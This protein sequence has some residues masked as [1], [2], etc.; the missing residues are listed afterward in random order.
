WIIDDV[1]IACKF[2][3]YQKDCIEAL[4]NKQTTKSDISDVIA[5]I[6]VF[7]PFMPTAKMTKWFGPKLLHKL[8]TTESMELPP[9]DFNAVM[10]A[11]QLCTNG[12]LKEA[13]KSLDSLDAQIQ[14]PDP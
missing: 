12:E 6:G 9:I 3:E 5:I 11:I 14:S 13:I 4:I 10:K 8:V 2:Q 1:C 7:A